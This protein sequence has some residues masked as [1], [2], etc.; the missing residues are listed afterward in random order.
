MADWFR[1][2]YI[3]AAEAQDYID[4][5]MDMGFDCLESL[6]SATDEDIQQVIA[7]PG[8]QRMIRNHI[9]D[10]VRLS[11]NS[12]EDCLWQW[13]DC[14]RTNWV[15]G[16]TTDAEDD[17]WFNYSRDVIRR[18]ETA[19]LSQERDII[20]FAGHNQKYRI[21]IVRMKQVNMRTGHTRDIRRTP[22]VCQKINPP[23]SMLC[24]IGLALMTDPVMAADGH[25]Y[26]RMNI[27]R[28]LQDHDS[29]PKTMLHLSNKNLIPNHSLRNAIE[30]FKQMASQ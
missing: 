12:R 3:P 23:N 8:H 9:P 16:A 22:P 2:L 6:S 5:F 4:T 26:E 25:S 30:E 11:H 21:D 29:S 1:S 27:E 10:L 7:K 13:D 20:V 19:R 17:S 24:P 28:W 14:V 18:I 15:K